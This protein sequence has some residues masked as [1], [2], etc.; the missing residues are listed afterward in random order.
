MFLKF[1]NKKTAHKYLEECTKTNNNKNKYGKTV[2]GRKIAQF[3][4]C[5][6]LYPQTL[7]AGSLPNPSSTQEG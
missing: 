4:N 1:Q 2:N 7:K 5:L 3:Q 6:Y